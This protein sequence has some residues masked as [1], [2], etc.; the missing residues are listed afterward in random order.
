MTA[1]VRASGRKIRALSSET[2]LRAFPR[3]ME[4]DGGRISSVVSGELEVRARSA[5]I[6]PGGIDEVHYRDKVEHPPD[7]Y[8]S[9]FHK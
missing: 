6:V 3:R 7:A 1:R 4:W 2:S 8:L 9:P 5:T